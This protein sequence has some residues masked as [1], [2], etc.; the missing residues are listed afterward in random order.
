MRIHQ[1]SQEDKSQSVLGRIALWLLLGALTTLWGFLFFNKSWGTPLGS[2]TYDKGSSGWV[3][4]IGDYLF[5]DMSGSNISWDNQ[6]G[7]LFSGELLTGLSG[8]TISYPTW[9]MEQFNKALLI[10]QNDSLVN[11]YIDTDNLNASG[12]NLITINSTP[13]MMVAPQLQIQWSVDP[14]IDKLYIIWT[15][16]DG[17]YVFDTVP[18]ASNFWV[19]QVD[20]KNK[21]IKPGANTYYLI[22]K[23]QENKYILGYATIKTYE[24]SQFYSTLDKIC[25]F[26]ICTDPN[27][28]KT[29]QAWSETIL[30]QA[31]DGSKVIQIIPDISATIAIKCNNGGTA[32]TQ[33]IKKT[34]DYYHK[35]TKSCG[36]PNISQSFIDQNGNTIADNLVDIKLPS[37]LQFGNLRYLGPKFSINDAQKDFRVTSKLDANTLATIIKS[38]LSVPNELAFALPNNLYAYYTLDSSQLKLIRI[39][40]PDS[41]YK[42]IPKLV[43]WMNKNIVYTVT[44]TDVW[45]HDTITSYFA[46][47]TIVNQQ[48]CSSPKTH[49]DPT[50]KFGILPINKDF[51]IVWFWNCYGITD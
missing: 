31:P 7:G 19:Y 40:N 39:S 35:V 42:V 37:V 27:L 11:T 38:D 15:N 4:S 14:S 32:I 50:A 12:F 13:S 9:Y 21:N 18:I 36:E 43:E 41:S 6:T 49:K 23:T 28:P 48:N 33:Q 51:D 17:A 34:G 16:K 47:Q 22:A 29:V 24:S 26:D 5:W 10:L 3:P 1:I 20:S 2:S 25:L 30:Q 44:T 46:G 45:L 8:Q